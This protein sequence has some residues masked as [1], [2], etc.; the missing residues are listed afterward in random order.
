MKWATLRPQADE[1]LGIPAEALS[2]VGKNGERFY[3]AD[4]RHIL[5][6]EQPKAVAEAVITFLHKQP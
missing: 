5:P 1:G 4:A 6:L 2:L 3:E